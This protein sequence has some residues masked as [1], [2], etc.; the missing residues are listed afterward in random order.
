MKPDRWTR[1][2]DCGDDPRHHL[3][4]RDRTGF[5]RLLW[6]EF[7]KFRTVRAWMIALCAAAA[8]FVLLSFLSAFES[9]APVPAPPVGAG[10]EAVSDTYTFMS[11][12]LAGDGTLTARVASL[13]GGYTSLSPTLS[14]GLG[15]SSKVQPGSQLHPGL[16]PWAKAGIILEPDT[17]Q[18]TDY[19]AVMV[20]GSHGVQMQDDY[21]HDSPG[22]VGAVGAPSPRW[23][24]LTRAGDVITGYDSTDGTHWTK[25][26]TAR[27]TGLPHMV[28]VGLFVTSPVYFPAGADVGTPS[29]ATASF[30][31]VSARGDLPRRSW[32]G[33]AI[34]GSGFYPL[35]PSASTWQQRSAGAFTISGSGD[36]APL[37]GDIISAQWAG[38]SIVNGTIAAL[39]FVIV[40]GTLFATSEYRHGLIR[41]T[42]AACPHRGRV[43]AAKTVVAGS[44]A[45]AAGAIATAIAEVITRRVLAANGSYLFPQCGPDLAR[46][47]I[48]TGLFLGLAAALAVALGTMLRRSAVAIAAAIVLL[49]LPGILGS[50]SGN[51]LM[52]LTPTAAFAIQATLPRSNLVTSAYTPP[53][54]YFPIGPWAGLGALAAYTAAALAAATWLLLRRDA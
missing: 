21:T 14:S 19:A 7:T 8:V 13:S 52:R 37:V 1:L 47:I 15:E 17:N 2:H 16:A 25:I 30:D 10:G 23:L 46:V 40:L 36:I 12:P 27:L 31:Q 39:L 26:G 5:I 33:D 18:G 48:G 53:N 28:Q 45:F 9:R 51:W 41:A 20:T 11:Q 35:V 22:L 6:A 38:A 32:T 29:V 54:G 42:F 24:R 44:L 3:A 50:Q 49:V 34:T 43:L 4:A